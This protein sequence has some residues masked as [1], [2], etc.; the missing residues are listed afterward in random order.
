MSTTIGGKKREVKNYDDDKYV[1]LFEAE[2][3][4]INPD[5]QQF[6]EILNIELKEDSKATEYLGEKD[7]NTTLRL[8]IWVKDVK[9]EKLFK[10]T[11]WLE[12]IIRENKEGSKKQYVN[13]IGDLT[14]AIDESYI[15]SWFTKRDYRV[16]RKGEEE[17]YTFL[18]AW[19]G[20]LDYRDA[21][22]VLEV[23]WKSLMKGNVKALRDQIGGEWSTTYLCL[24]TIKASEKEDGTTAHY[25]SVYARKYLPTYCLKQFRLLDYD[26][27]HVINSLTES[28]TKLKIHEKFVKDVYGEYGPKDF[29]LLKPMQKY[30]PS[31]NPVSTSKAIIE[32]DESAQ[33]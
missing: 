17:L 21:E 19:L 30:E 27:P 18:R 5:A 7:G 32:S 23:D 29:F 31:M 15:S 26:A 1:G 2:V 10:K 6:K 8:D 9:T 24:A 14:W 12:D 25:Q 22:T 33:F 13:S 4:A 20:N 11:F 16:A 3:V 28:K